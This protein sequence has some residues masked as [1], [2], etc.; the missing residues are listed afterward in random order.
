MPSTR[1]R[2]RSG[3]RSS[4]GPTKSELYEQARSLGVEGRSKMDKAQLARAVSRR[5]Q[6]S[7]GRRSSEPRRR[8]PANPVEVQSFLEGVG[9]PTHK[10]RLVEET[11]S[12]GASRDIRETI[13]QLPERQFNSP[14]EVSEA[15]GSL[16]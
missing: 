8:T 5:E 9:Y 7:A 14:T 1:G 16:R 12:R 13:E 11:R 6:P 3:S 10:R 2:S 4:E 15:I